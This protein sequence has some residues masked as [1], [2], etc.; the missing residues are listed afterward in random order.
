MVW[1]MSPLTTDKKSQGYGP[2]QIIWDVALKAAA[3]K[4]TA[5][6]YKDYLTEEELTT[7]DGA[8]RAIL[9]PKKSIYYTAMVLQYMVT[10]LKETAFADESVR[11]PS[12]V[13]P[14]ISDKSTARQ[15]ALLNLAQTL[16][17]FPEGDEQLD[18]L[19]LLGPNNRFWVD[20]FKA[21]K[22]FGIKPHLKGIRLVEK[23]H[24]ML[25]YKHLG[26]PFD[27]PY[28]NLYTGG[29]C[30]VSFIAPL[31]PL[32]RLMQMFEPE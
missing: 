8:L 12:N 32:T 18:R 17:A 29:L 15:M 27:A 30:L 19:I 23:A 14:F 11:Y 1:N 4:E 22:M 5:A 7:E 2:A 10:R 6:Y 16:S 26:E 25:S 31:D 13:F 20:V 9:D 21:G 3:H 28:N 24:M